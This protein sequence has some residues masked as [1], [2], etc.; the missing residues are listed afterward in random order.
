LKGCEYYKPETI[1]EAMKMMSTLAGA[2]YIAGGTD[3]MVLVKQKKLSPDHLISL[4]NIRGL[5]F[6]DTAGGLRMGGG[7]THSK[8]ARNEFIQNRYSA[9]ADAAGKIGSTQ[10][11]NVATVGGNICNAAPSA[12]TAC[13]LLVLDAKIVI[14]GKKGERTVAVEDFFLGPNRTVLE[15]G[16]IVREITIPELDLNSGSAYIKHTRRKAMELPLVGIAARITLDAAS[17]SPEWKESLRSLPNAEALPGMLEAAGIV[18][19]DARIAM[20][21]VS[22]KPMRARKAEAALAGQVVSGALLDE[23]GALAL[24]ESQPRDSFRG[25]AWYRKD[26]VRVLVRRAI[27]MS[28]ERIV[29][30]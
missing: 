10:V 12:D 7:T 14:V 24:S 8:I 27:L 2:R 4:R 3:V 17:H 22:P 15:Q 26:M 9:L 23:I 18:C 19:R 13:P 1:E 30:A 11:R 28:I 25:E 5:S 29:S 20:G 21:V 6:I 16:D